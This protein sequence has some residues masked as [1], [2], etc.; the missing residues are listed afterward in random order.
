MNPNKQG[1]CWVDHGTVGSNAVYPSLR[2]GSA[3]SLRN[4]SCASA[5]RQWVPLAAK[6]QKKDERSE[7]CAQIKNEA[8]DQSHPLRHFYNQLAAS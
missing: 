2:S 7:Q 3:D 5:P 6:R 8:G 1:V 4:F